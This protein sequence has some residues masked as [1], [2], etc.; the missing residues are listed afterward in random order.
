MARVFISY[1]RR[2]NAYVAEMLRDA[3]EERFGRNEVFFDLDN[4]PFGVDFREY[5]ANAV[6][7][8]DVLLVVIGD[9]WLHLTGDDGKRRLDNPSDY[10][11]VEIESALKR[12]IPVV[13]VL[14]EDARMPSET[15][16]PEPIKA[17]AFRNAA[18]I[19]AG[20]DRKQQIA[21]LVSDLERHWAVEVSGAPKVEPPRPTEPTRS[22]DVRIGSP[23]K[24]A[25]PM[26]S[27]PVLDFELVGH[28]RSSLPTTNPPRYYKHWI[29]KDDGSCT[30]YFQSDDPTAEH[31][32][33]RP[34]EGR[35]E[36]KN[37]R[38]RIG[39]PKDTPLTYPYRI[40]RD[41]LILTEEGMFRVWERV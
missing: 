12:D 9:Q 29:L 39:F 28:W 36:A 14:I 34:I 19:R 33:G 41:K 11:R 3:V 40:D 32:G 6:G 38:L 4:I 21:R 5:I 35:W 8:C 1:R 31:R 7:S 25:Q 30:R 37:G 13:P 15:D 24:E 16:L 10:V 26:A 2:D 27:V 20:R 17:M 23:R 22:V 18:E